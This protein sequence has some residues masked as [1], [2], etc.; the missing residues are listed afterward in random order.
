MEELSETGIE[1][2]DLWQFD[3]ATREWGMLKKS[4]VP[5]SSRS[6]FCMALH[7]KRLVV[8]GGVHDEDTD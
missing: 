1:Y 8:F 2:R 6:G 7:R 5:P 4:G 3:V